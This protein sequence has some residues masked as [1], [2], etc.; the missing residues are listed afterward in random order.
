MI[1]VTPAKAGSRA[2]A[3]TLAPWIPAFAGMTDNLL[4]A[5]ISA[6]ARQMVRI[7]TEVGNSGIDNPPRVL[8]QL[9]QARM[10]TGGAWS[11][12]YEPQPLLDQILELAAAQRRLRLGPAV[13][14]I[15]HL[16]SSLHGAR[17]RSSTSP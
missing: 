17:S 5:A 2:P 7:R 10:P 12:E 15:R 14:S 6:K 11:F 8:H 4:M 16:D 3:R 1:L 13:K 9:G